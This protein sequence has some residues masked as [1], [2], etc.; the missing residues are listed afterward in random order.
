MARRAQLWYGARSVGE[1]A[2][3]GR[4]ANTGTGNRYLEEEFLPWWNQHLVVGPAHPADAHRPLGPEHQLAATLSHVEAGPADN[5]YTIRLDRKVCQI[6]R[7]SIVAGL[8]GAIVRVERRLDGSLAVGFRERYL[9][10]TECQRS[11]KPPVSSKPTAQ[12]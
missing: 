3:G 10:V 7:S 5:D 6:D 12:A 4:R 9:T 2:A 11:A 1:G 8:R